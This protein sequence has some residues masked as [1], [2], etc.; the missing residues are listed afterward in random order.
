VRNFVAAVD[1]RSLE[2]VRAISIG[3][4]TSEACRANGIE[5]VAEA[6]KHDL[7]GLVDAIV[8]TLGNQER[9]ETVRGG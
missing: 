4:V 9:A 5:V 7:D 1:G 3:P 6:W 8:S 2:R